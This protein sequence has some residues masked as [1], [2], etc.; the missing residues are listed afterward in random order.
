MFFFA[1]MCLCIV[2]SYASPTA[3][4]S[5]WLPEDAFVGCKG[6]NLD[7]GVVQTNP[8]GA[9]LTCRLQLANSHADIASTDSH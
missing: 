3:H 6:R 2:G 5:V 4:L 7:Y 1:H 9:K 8:W